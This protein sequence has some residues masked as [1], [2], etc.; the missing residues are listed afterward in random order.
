MKQGAPSKSKEKRCEEAGKSRAETDRSLEV[1]K[2]KLAHGLIETV[3]KQ[4]KLPSTLSLCVRIET[5]RKYMAE[6]IEI[7]YSS[8]RIH[9]PI[10]FI[11]VDIVQATIKTYESIR[12]DFKEV[13]GTNDEKLER[14]F[15]K[16]E[17]YFERRE[18]AFAVLIK[19]MEQEKQMSDYS[20]RMF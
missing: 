8:E 3:T 2:E 20:V 18:A 1:V 13:V 5:H 7:I 17:A 14:L 9:S 10:S 12:E 11:E 16:V 19:I 4:R 6:L 15:P